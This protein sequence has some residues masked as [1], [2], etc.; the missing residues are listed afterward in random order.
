MMNVLA[1]AA[2]AAWLLVFG[3]CAVV[4][5]RP[6]LRAGTPNPGLGL[7]PERSAL[8]NLAVTRCRLNG[9]AY[10]ATILGLAAKGFLGITQR[11]S[12]QL[13]CDV[14]AS[15]PSEAGLARSERLV[16]AGTTALAAADGAPFEALAQSCASDVRGRWDPFERAVRAEGR[17]SGI[18]R[19][20]LSP[21]AR[22]GLYAGA[23]GVCVLAYA[24]VHSH[25]QSGLWAPVVTA[26]FAFAVPAYWAH[27]LGRQD[28]LTADGSALGAWAARAASDL[29]AA[30]QPSP[31]P[32]SSPAELGQLAWAVAAGALVQIPGTAPGLVT[33]GRPGRARAGARTGLSGQF[34][35]TPRPAAAWSSFG[36]Q[37]RM[38]RI[39]PT[40]FS[41]MHPAFWL[42]LAAW[43]GLMAYVSSLLPGP[44]GVL[45]A[46]VLAAGAAAAAVGGTRG[47]AAW[48]ARLAETSFQAQVIAR[49][50]EN[51]GANDDSHI[52]CIAVDDGERSWSFDVSGAAF[53]QLALGDTVSV[54]ASPRS[55]K[56][57]GM[58]PLP[59]RTG[60]RTA[61]PGG[62]GTDPEPG[63]ASADA[64]D[65]GPPRDPAAGDAAAGTRAVG[66]EADVV[67][68]GA[69]LAAGEVSAAVGR[70]VRA[71]A[72]MPSA[73]GTLYRGEGVTVTVT[74]ADGFLGSLTSLARRRGRP[75]PGAGREAWLLNGGR[76]AVLLAGGLTAKVTIGGSAARSLPPD[77][78]PR[79]AA[80][81]A[82]RLAQRAAPCGQPSF[83]GF[84]DHEPGQSNGAPGWNS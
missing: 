58:M 65:D 56:L 38:V 79:L 77:A 82:G 47:L 74:V 23:G 27:A 26:F 19:P 6:A 48:L 37:W 78:L 54:R 18:T 5:S 67:L 1:I 40:P 22:A 81:V 14:P 44:A 45:A 21:A 4:T 15:P 66:E 83:D 2:A 68:P 55:G 3:W 7:A 49:W 41:S 12:E 57:L 34:A 61:A 69:L 24:A 13:W 39:G 76:T 71:T 84:G 20:R 10:P 8:V 9:A 53:G 51:R 16:L 73:G 33:G 36:G 50:V 52:T 25:P 31:P 80:A 11:G 32:I 43:L 17:Q 75:L 29:A 28:R 62:P 70:P 46:G 60:D 64:V 63:R 30:A 35:E 72:P 42:V 59:D